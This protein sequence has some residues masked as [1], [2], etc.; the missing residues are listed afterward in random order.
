MSYT[1][2]GATV[3]TSFD[4]LCGPVATL[5]I[6]EQVF[7]NGYESQ[8]PLSHCFS[9]EENYHQGRSQALSQFI[10]IFGFRELYRV[11]REL[12]F[13][14]VCRDIKTAAGVASTVKHLSS[15]KS[16]HARELSTDIV[17]FVVCLLYWIESWLGGGTALASLGSKRDDTVL[18]R[19]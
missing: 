9:V 2:Y 17:D 4:W 8:Y 15:T 3:W 13:P 5:K 1:I 19:F 7:V 14:N 12:I 16:R 11:I 6:R 10:A 18:F